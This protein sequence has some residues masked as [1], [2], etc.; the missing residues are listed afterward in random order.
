MLKK[1][2]MLSP[3]PTPIPE[4]VVAKFAQPIIHHR[5]AAF[6]KLFAEVKTG[7]KKLFQ[8]KQDS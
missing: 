1:N 6:E 4:S 7:L 2:Y 3:G 8:T 5:T